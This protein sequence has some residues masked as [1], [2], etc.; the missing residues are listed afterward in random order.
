MISS[1]SLIE[2]LE[3]AA[4]SA[5]RVPLVGGLLERDY[6]RAFFKRPPNR[7]MGVFP[8]FAAAAQAV[9]LDQRVGYDH[10]ELAGMYRHRMDKACQSDYAM[11]FWLKDLLPDNPFVVD[12]G[13]HV[14]VSFYGWKSY[15]N[16]P[17]NLRWLVYEV[18]AIVRGGLQ[19][20]AERDSRGLFFTSTLADGRDC[21]IFMAA[22]SLQYV[23]SSLP[24]LLRDLGS[25]PRHLFINKLPVYD[26]ES[27]VTLQ[28]TGRALHPYRIFNRDEFL[29][30]VTDLGYHLVDDWVNREQHC[31]IPFTRGRDIDAY[32]GF[33]FRLA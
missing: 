28:S 23:D 12:Y 21:N 11:L 9:P 24:A 22:G 15:L 8:G 10:D 31:E 32:S 4:R 19:L 29:R 27:F 33:Y 3:K 26:G 16:Y 13:G 1:V 14:G 2:F 6:A 25:K 7:F 20:A 17:S 5:W 18:P 30:E